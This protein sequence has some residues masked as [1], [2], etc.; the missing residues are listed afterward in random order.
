MARELH[1]AKGG[2][3]ER[4][5]AQAVQQV[6]LLQPKMWPKRDVCSQG[7]HTSGEGIVVKPW[8]G[9]S[10]WPSQ[11]LAPLPDR[12]Q[13]PPLTCSPSTSV[14][15]YVPDS[16]SLG[17]LPSWRQLVPY[18]SG[19]RGSLPTWDGRKMSA[20]VQCPTH[21]HPLPHTPTGPVANHPAW[22]ASRCALRPLGKP[23]HRIP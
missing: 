18:C 6:Q 14:S 19:H 12:Q 15:I 3:V 2:K 11:S 9:R 20:R 4:W 21:E 22:K 23:G 13:S 10:H 8:R 16:R 1:W 7:Q 5:G 17:Q